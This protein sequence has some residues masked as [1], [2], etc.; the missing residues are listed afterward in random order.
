MDIS[1]NSLY[2]QMQGMS[3]QA[4]GPGIA[5]ANGMGAVQTIGSENEG[6][7]KP[8]NTS[9][10]DFGSLLK[11]AI[12]SVNEIQQEAGSMKK[13]FELGDSSVSLAQTMVTTQKAGL[14]FDATLQVR[15]KLLE[16]Y[17]EIMSMPV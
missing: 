11:D 17:K 3:L 10:S 1:G 2:A 16:A 15:N 4:R 14:A 6:G 13:A 5:G 12:G 9:S 7:I 8:V